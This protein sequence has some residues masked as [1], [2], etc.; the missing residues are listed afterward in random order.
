MNCRKPDQRA[1]HRCLPARR[2]VKAPR[3]RRDAHGGRDRGEEGAE[4]VAPAHLRG[5][6]AKTGWHKETQKEREVQNGP[7]Q[8]KE[9]QT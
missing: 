1:D 9:S 6:V 8:K 3:P 4:H 2:R 5:I 7:E